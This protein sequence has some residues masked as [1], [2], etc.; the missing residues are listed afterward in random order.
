M[1]VALPITQHNYAQIRYTVT[2]TLT[3]QQSNNSSH[4]TITLHIN[5]LSKG[6][7]SFRGTRRSSARRGERRQA[8]TAT[9][10][11]QMTGRRPLRRQ[12]V[13]PHTAGTR[14][15]L[16]KRVLVTSSGRREVHAI[17]PLPAYAY[18]KS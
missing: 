13:R 17:I 7:Q 8:N 6:S 14:H 18:V 15:S 9:E 2:N 10:V 11:H 5:K 16:S 4:A 3:Q 12:A 1:T